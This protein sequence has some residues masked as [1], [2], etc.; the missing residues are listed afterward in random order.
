MGT[1]PLNE[2][3]GARRDTPAASLHDAPF[4]N[5]SFIERTA[6]S[7]APFPCPM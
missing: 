1:E 7:K 5:G 2:M 4:C 6:R 3:G